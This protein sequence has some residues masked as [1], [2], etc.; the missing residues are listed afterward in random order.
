[1][2]SRSRFSR[3][4]PPRAISIAPSFACNPGFPQSRSPRPLLP[5]PPSSFRSLSLPAFP[6]F[7]R[8]PTRSRYRSP[9]LVGVPEDAP[10]ASTRLGL[11]TPAPLSLSPHFARPHSPCSRLAG[12]APPPISAS[13]SGAWPRARMVIRRRRRAL[14]LRL[15]FCRP[16]FVPLRSLSNPPPLPSHAV[17][18]GLACSCS[19]FLC[20]PLD[21]VVGFVRA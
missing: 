12:G 21:G 5:L 7:D 4:S 14:F 20:S 9:S 16:G 10:P 6:Q 8:S 15:S 17:C 2:L 3:F 19:P 11:P 13:H 1:M 18:S